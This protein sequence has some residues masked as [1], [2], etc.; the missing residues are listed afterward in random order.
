MRR[1][2]SALPLTLRQLLPLAQ[3]FAYMQTC[4][5]ATGPGVR[6]LSPG[7]VK[8]R[9]SAAAVHLCE[10]PPPPEPD[11][12]QLKNCPPAGGPP[13][14]LICSEQELPVGQAPGPLVSQ[15]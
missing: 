9:P 15:K 14:Q 10:S 12:T 1:H 8:K 13:F 7:W 5:S 2:C 3:S 11:F 4:P 6:H